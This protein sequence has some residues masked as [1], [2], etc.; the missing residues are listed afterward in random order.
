[1]PPVGAA[2]GKQPMARESPNGDIA[3]KKC[4]AYNPGDKNREHQRPPQ[5]PLLR[6]RGAAEHGGG[7]EQQHIGRAFDARHWARHARRRR[8]G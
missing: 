8:Q 3:R 1:M 4:G 6:E 5:Q 7:V 2:I